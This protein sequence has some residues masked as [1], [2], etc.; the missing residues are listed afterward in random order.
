MRERGRRLPARF[1]GGEAH[2]G[3]RVVDERAAPTV[4]GGTDQQL[5]D[6]HLARRHR[7]QVLTATDDRDALRDVVDGVGQRV[8]RR[9]VGAHQHRVGDLRPLEADLAAHQV[10]DDR[11]PLAGGRQPQR[12]RPPFGGEPLQLLRGVAELV[13]LDHRWAAL[14]GAGRGPPRL[15]LLGGAVVAV[16]MAARLQAPGH[17]GVQ[18]RTR[19]LPVR[20]VPAA[21]AAERLRRVGA[22]VPVQTD[23]VQRLDH[24][25]HGVLGGP[26][27]VGV[28]DAEHERAVVGAGM[29]PVVQR[30]PGAADVQHARGRRTEAD[31]GGR[32]HEVSEDESGGW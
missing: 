12:R 8:G 28:L 13:G 20:A 16:E 25:A 15:Q 26:R 7:Q 30:R 1:A 6:Q 10:V 5:V 29:Q 27:R 21:L 22:L 9:P 19:R 4:R 31:A 2:L 24:R 11:H 17:R 32:G 23:P 3:Q 18:R 14:A